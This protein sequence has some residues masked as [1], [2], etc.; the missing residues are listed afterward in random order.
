V[1]ILQFKY[2]HNPKALWTVDY[3]RGL[4]R[5][6]ITYNDDYEDQD[7]QPGS[8][9]NYGYKDELLVDNGAYDGHSIDDISEYSDVEPALKDM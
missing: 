2:S 4:A 8:I 5:N 9:L 7:I 3:V 6:V 1:F